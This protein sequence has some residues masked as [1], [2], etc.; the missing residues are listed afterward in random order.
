MVVVASF[1]TDVWSDDGAVDWIFSE[2]RKNIDAL[3]D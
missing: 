1:G 3:L 2:D